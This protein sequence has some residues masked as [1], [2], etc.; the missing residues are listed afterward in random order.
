[1]KNIP[2]YRITTPTGAWYETDNRGYVVRC[3]NGLNK[4]NAS[5]HTLMTW[6]ITGI[7]EVDNFGRV[8]SLIRLDS[9]CRMSCIS[10]LHKNKT[11][12]YAIEDIDHGTRRIQGNHKLYGV[13]TV[14][15]I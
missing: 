8:G 13:S 5:L 2:F 15:L 7:R 10:L 14:S 9:A 11:P 12:R 4:T 1:M 3:N 6:Q